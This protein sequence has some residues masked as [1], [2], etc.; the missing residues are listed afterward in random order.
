M[1]YS[2]VKEQ[3]RRCRFNVPIKNESRIKKQRLKKKR[4]DWRYHFSLFFIIHFTWLKTKMKLHSVSYQL[5]KIEIPKN[6]F[7]NIFGNLNWN[8][9]NF[10][11]N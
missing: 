3:H 8:N 7:D 2:R 1:V 5:E 10:S 4:P 9:L 6:L 11:R